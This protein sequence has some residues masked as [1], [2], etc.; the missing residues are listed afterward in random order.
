MYTNK[1]QVV[2]K[3]CFAIMLVVSCVSHEQKT[4]DAYNQFKQ[5]KKIS[6]DSIVSN[7]KILANALKTESVKTKVT[8]DN[9][10][11]FINEIERKIHSNEYKIREMKSISEANANLLKK[12]STL[13]NNNND[14]RKQ[15]DEFNE[16]MNV[17]LETFK[18]KL[19]HDANEISIELKE[20]KLNNR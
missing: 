19:N 15:I 5:E 14:L 3:C 1:I 10:T 12:V 2:V 18:L 17:K 16:D 6:K 20:L 13:E 7:N 11:V 9:W 8:P 4:D